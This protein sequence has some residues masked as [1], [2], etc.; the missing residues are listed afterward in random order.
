[1][2]E[3]EGDLMEFVNKVPQDALEQVILY[4][5]TRGETWRYPLRQLMQHLANH[6][7]YR[8]GQVTTMLRQLGAE[9]SANRFTTVFRCRC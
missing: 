7:S 9:E 4:T 3:V 1:M 8:R 5:N 6:S 2:A